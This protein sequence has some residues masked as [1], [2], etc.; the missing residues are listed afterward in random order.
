MDVR[1]P[2]RS[3]LVLGAA[4][5]LVTGM[6][7]PAALPGTGQFGDPEPAGFSSEN[8][9][10][11]GHVP[12]H[13]GTA[14][15][16]LHGDHYYLTDPRG[17]YI[18]EVEDPS[19]PT[20]VGALPA[21]QLSTH[22]VFAQEEPDTN[23]EIL[24][25]DAVRPEALESGAP[26]TNGWL[27]VVDVSD[28][29]DPH[30]IGSLAI[31]DHTWTCVLDCSYAIGRR[32]PI[33]DLT[34][35]TDPH[36][37]A[38]WRDHVD[39]D[40]YMHDFVEVAPGRV[41]GAG[42][43]SVYLDLNDPRNPVELA[44]VDSDFHSLGYH[45][46]IWPNDATDPLMLLGAEVAPEG[47][48]NLAGSDCNDE[49]AHAVATY[50]ATAVIEVDE[51]HFNERRPRAQQRGQKRGFAQQREGADF[52]KLHEWRIDGRG[53]YADGHAPGHLLFCGHW[54][55]AHPDW[56]AGGTLAIAHYDW[57]VRFLDVG[58]DGSMTEVDWW[59]PVGGY[60]GAAY[61]ITD[62]ILYVHD[63]RR[64]IDILRFTGTED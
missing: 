51:R 30:V 62:E 35:P 5:L 8:V 6:S 49:S 41:I 17:V 12:G 64:G 48:M 27:L 57:G 31:F 18:Y 28:P 21:Q 40:D 45:G 58:S 26:T 9:E 61:W 50:D 59:Q 42:Q 36:V 47:A 1:R 32:G 25:V 44:R 29:S 2:L 16:I 4:A 34:D 19:S 39:G 23:G 33:V 56:D 38:N 22:I 24:L 63:Y 14:G 53:A 15:G 7:F 37:I 52:V 20:L 13:S 10:W 3:V 43:P 46:A 55:Q 60:T 54:F 11:V